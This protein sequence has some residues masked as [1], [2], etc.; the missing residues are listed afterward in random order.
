MLKLNDGFACV[1][2]PVLGTGLSGF[3]FLLSFYDVIFGRGGLDFS[4]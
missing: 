1:I 3:E 2:F 4:M